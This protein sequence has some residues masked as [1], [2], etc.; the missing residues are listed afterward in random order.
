M[1]E[2]SR[3]AELR[4]DYKAQFDGAYVKKCDKADPDCKDTSLGKWPD[5]DKNAT[6]DLTDEPII[7][8]IVQGDRVLKKMEVDIKGVGSLKNMKKIL[9][10]QGIKIHDND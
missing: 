6:K 2:Y 3:A 7:F 10:K 9:S 5:P 4:G 1:A 8:L